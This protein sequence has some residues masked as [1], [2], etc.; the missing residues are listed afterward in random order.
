MRAVSVT[1]VGLL[2][3]AS[4]WTVLL[5]ADPPRDDLAV[6]LMSASLWATT[7]IS[8]TGMLVAR[9]R[10]ARRLGI[11]VTGGHGAVAI[12]LTPGLWWGVGM[13]LSAATALALSGPWLDGY[14]RGRP[15]A[16]GP[17]TRAVLVPLVLAGVPFA[18]GWA[19]AD[20]VPGAALAASAWVAAFWFIRTLP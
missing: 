12:L 4:L 2:L 11:V 16:A 17:P 15:S 18:L 19:G 13:I 3:S 14:I 8:L 7:V 6:I 9:A 5:A 10:W 20:N 1:S